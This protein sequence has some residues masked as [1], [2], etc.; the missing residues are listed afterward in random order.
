MAN[1]RIREVI[2]NMTEYSLA[3]KQDGT[4]EFWTN[5][6]ELRLRIEQYIKDV[7]DAISYRRQIICRY[8]GELQ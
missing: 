4:I 3:E 5:D 8:E 6:E 1:K 2:N 7:V